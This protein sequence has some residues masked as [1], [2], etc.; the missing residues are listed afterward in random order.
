MNIGVSSACLYPMLTEKSLDKLINIGFRN[1]EI[2]INSDRELKYEYI[3][4]IISMLDKIGGKVV[5]IHPYI[6]GFEPC[7]IFSD[8]YR[9]F[10]D[11]MYIYEKFFKAANAYNAKYVVMHGDKIRDRILI[12]DEEYFKR[13]EILSEIADKYSVVLAQENVNL[14]RSSDPIFIR[15]MRAYLKDKANFI[16]DIKQCVR[17]RCSPFD[18]LNAMGRNVV[19]VHASDHNDESDCI[20]PGQGNFDFVKLKNMLLE[21]EYKGDVIIELYNSGFSSLDELH[22]SYLYLGRVLNDMG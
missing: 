2:F 11:S 1:F 20:L 22:N 8:Y 10:E 19:L 6:S 17:S 16:L 9:R 12:T 4:K 3:S 14:F 7:L 21:N 15:N 18:M 5:S 13:F